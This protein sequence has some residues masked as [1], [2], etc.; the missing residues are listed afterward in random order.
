MPQKTT[1]SPFLEALGASSKESAP[2][3]KKISIQLFTLIAREGPATPVSKLLE[4][5]GL[6]FTDFAQALTA[7]ESAGLAE[8][9]GSGSNQVVELTDIGSRLAT[10]VA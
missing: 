3:S 8:V 6:G 7:M 10:I 4:Q 2:A 9:K 1:I 5:S